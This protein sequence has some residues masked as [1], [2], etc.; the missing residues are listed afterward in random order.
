M[1]EKNRIKY[2]LTEE[3]IK[4]LKLPYASHLVEIFEID[5]IINSRKNFSTIDKIEHLIKL[6]EAL[7]H[8]LEMIH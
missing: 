2:G 1:R 5:K 6:K 3:Q 4:Q 8:K 7:I